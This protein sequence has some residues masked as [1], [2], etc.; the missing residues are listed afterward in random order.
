[1]ALARGTADHPSADPLPEPDG[2]QPAWAASAGAKLL[3]SVFIASGHDPADAAGWEDHFARMVARLRA[4]GKVTGEATQRAAA[5]HQ[6]LH[7]EILHGDYDPVVSDPAVALA[8]GAYNCAGTSALFL[9]LAREFSLEA[10]AVS[11]VG[12]V[13]CR[14][15]TATGPLDVETTCRDWFSLLEG[16]VG[17]VDIRL[18]GHHLARDRAFQTAA[19]RRLDDRALLAI[20]HFNRG[21]GRFREGRFAAAAAANFAALSL[22]AR[23]APAYEN[24]AAALVAWSLATLPHG[25]AA[26]GGGRAR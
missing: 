13:W 21:V 15:E 9:A 19:I 20:F 7:A 14:V 24:L 17:T 10:H 23:C 11:V 18:P 1:M 4:G 22:D 26:G 2:A 12:H 8:G 6:F 16:S 3:R 25:E 5:I